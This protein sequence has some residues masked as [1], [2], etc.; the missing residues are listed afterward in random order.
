LSGFCWLT[1]YPGGAS[2]LCLVCCIFCHCWND[3]IW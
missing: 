2:V 3:S 1:S